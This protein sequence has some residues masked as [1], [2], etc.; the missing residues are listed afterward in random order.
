MAAA[1]AMREA[2]VAVAAV[3]LRRALIAAILTAIAIGLGL[4]RLPAGDEGRQALDVA[5]VPDLRLRLR[6]YL[7]LILRLRTMV[8]LRAVLLLGTVLLRLRL[9]RL[10]LRLRR[11]GLAIGLKTLVAIVTIIA[12]VAGLILSAALIAEG[13]SLA[14][15][16][17][18]RGDDAEIMLGVLIEVFG[19]DGI[20]GPLRV[21]CELQI[22]FGNVRGCAS[23]LHLGSIRLIDSGYR[24]LGLA[25]AVP[26]TL[27]LSVSH[28]VPFCQPTCHAAS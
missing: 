24:I 17:L 12:V 19:A 5:V 11:E 16:L 21:A 18:R 2:I 26:H 4:H 8:L 27:V 15:L 28:R 14:E 10:V 6:L 7:W 1:A 9:A 23:Y 13:L 20:S 22:F 3:L 25:I